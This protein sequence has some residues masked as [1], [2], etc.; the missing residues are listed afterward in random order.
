MKITDATPQNIAAP[1]GVNPKRQS[2]AA[3]HSQGQSE[4]AQGRLVKGEVLS[5][6]S[7]GLTRIAIGGRNISA[8]SLVPLAPGQEVWLEVIKE[9]DVPLLGVATRKGAVVDLM[10]QLFILG[11]GGTYLPGIGAMASL[12]IGAEST[13]DKTLSQLFQVFSLYQESLQGPTADPGK[14]IKALTLLGMF[15]PAQSNQKGK[16][17]NAPPL[18]G[19]FLPS[20]AISEEMGN[21]LKI[22]EGHAHV[23]SKPVGQEQQNFL[24]FPCF[25]AGNCGWGEWLLSLEGNDDPGGDGSRY[26]LTFF[27]EMSNLGEVHVRITAQGKTLQ[28]VFS[29]ANEKSRN[30]L[31]E[32]IPELSGILERLGYTSVQLSSQL[33]T[34]NN[35]QSLKDTLSKQTGHSTF[36]LLDT[37]I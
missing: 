9:G 36:A 34:V 4:L 1:D 13:A 33:A 14:I 17:G 35:L 29:M 24:L 25:F 15:T 20:P 23:N 21:V 12:G 2:A 16:T 32:N 10:R 18:S 37:T 26:G 28:G 19:P 6:A 22:F 3:S 7:D 27:L 8:R 30:F 31:I 5:V 11:R